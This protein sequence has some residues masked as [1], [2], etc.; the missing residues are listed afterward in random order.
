MVLDSEW[1]WIF[2]C[3]HFEDLRQKLPVLKRTIKDCYPF[4]P[5]GFAKVANLV[6]L[7]KEVQI[8]YRVAVSLGSFIRQAK[9]LRESWMREVFSRGRPCAPPEHWTRNIFLH[10]PSDADFPAEVAENFH[11][12][13]PW[14]TFID[15][16]S[17]A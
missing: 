16:I 4:D 14:F 2:D 11:D 12:G 9:A 15:D 1:H 5:R 10:P 6:S 8:Q 13:Q 17:A 7:L 3:P